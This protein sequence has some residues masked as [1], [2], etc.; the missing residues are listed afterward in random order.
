MLSVTNVSTLGSL[1]SAALNSQEFML[2]IEEKYR[3]GEIPKVPVYLDGMIYEAT[4][5]H[6][7][8][9]EFLNSNLRGT[10]CCL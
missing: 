2:V 6:T 5:I 4:S 10:S 7:A 9:P 3:L 8:Y 1:M